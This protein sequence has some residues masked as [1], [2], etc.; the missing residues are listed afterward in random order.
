[1]PSLA[2]RIQAIT[3]GNQDPETWAYGTST[4]VSGVVTVQTGLRSVACFNTML[5]GTGAH[6]SGVTEIAEIQVDVVPATGAV[7]CIGVY[8]AATGVTITSVSGTSSFYWM[9]VGSL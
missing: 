7:S 3:R 6:A 8:G 2:S 9:A 4:F 1:M 5:I